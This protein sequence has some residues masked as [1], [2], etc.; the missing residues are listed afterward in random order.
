VTYGKNKRIGEAKE[1]HRTKIIIF[2][3]KRKEE[4]N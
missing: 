1:R 4:E 2:I 3:R